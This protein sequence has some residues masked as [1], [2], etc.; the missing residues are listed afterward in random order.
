MAS[1]SSSYSLL[2][3]RLSGSASDLLNSSDS[4]STFPLPQ[5]S[6]KLGLNGEAY[7]EWDDD[8]IYP[9][10]DPLHEKVSSCKD[11]VSPTRRTPLS[12]TFEKVSVKKA[13]LFSAM[14]KSVKDFSTEQP[15]PTEQTDQPQKAE[16]AENTPKAN[17]ASAPDTV[18][19]PG[20]T[21]VAA[22]ERI[23]DAK[24]V[25]TPD[26]SSS[27][28]HRKSKPPTFQKR[29]MLPKPDAIP[30]PRSST[31]S[32]VPP[33]TPTPEVITID[34]DV[35]SEGPS[36]VHQSFSR[37]RPRSQPKPRPNIGRGTGFRSNKPLQRR[38]EVSDV[39]SARGTAKRFRAGPLLPKSPSVVSKQPT[40]MISVDSPSSLNESEKKSSKPTSF[41]N[42]QGQHITTVPLRSKPIVPS[43]VRRASSSMQRKTNSAVGKGRP[44]LINSSE[45]RI[46]GNQRREE[47]TR[48]S[49]TNN[50]EPPY[51][52]DSLL[53]STP[54]VAK[55]EQSPLS[56][57]NGPSKFSSDLDKISI[58][59]SAFSAPLGHVGNPPFNTGPPIAPDIPLFPPFPLPHSW[60]IPSPH[61]ANLNH[62]LGMPQG[63]HPNLAFPMPPNMHSFNAY[64]PFGNPPQDHLVGGNPMMAELPCPPH[65][66]AFPPPGISQQGLNPSPYVPVIAP[67]SGQVP[68][69]KRTFPYGPPRS[70]RNQANQVNISSSSRVSSDISQRRNNSMPTNHDEYKRLSDASLVDHYEQIARCAPKPAK[71]DSSNEQKIK[72]PTTEANDVSSARIEGNVSSEEKSPICNSD[73]SRK[74]SVAHR[75]PGDR[76]KNVSQTIRKIKRP[77]QSLPTDKAFTPT[78]GSS[79]SHEQGIPGPGQMDDPK[80]NISKLLE[81]A[82]EN[83]EL[84]DEDGDN[85]DYVS[86]I[87]ELAQKNSIVAALRWQFD[88]VSGTSKRWRCILT[89]KLLPYTKGDELLSRDAQSGVKKRA[90]HK[91]AKVFLEM[92]AEIRE[93]R[94]RESDKETEGVKD[95]EAKLDSGDGNQQSGAKSADCLEDSELGSNDEQ[96]LRQA[97][98]AL[99]SMWSQGYL[100]EKPEYT[101]DMEGEKWKAVVKVKVSGRD[102]ITV[103]CVAAQKK[104]ARQKV[105]L[106]ALQKLC[107][108]NVEGAEAFESLPDQ[109]CDIGSVSGNDSPQNVER[110]LLPKTDIESQARDA[111]ENLEDEVSWFVLPADYKILVATSENDCDEWFSN[112]VHENSHVGIYLDSFSARR[113]FEGEDNNASLNERASIK[114]PIICISTDKQGLVMQA[115]ARVDCGPNEYSDEIFWVPGA[116]ADVLECATVVKHGHSIMEGVVMLRDTFRVN[117]V[118]MD[119]VAVTSLAI[120]GVGNVQGEMFRTCLSELCNFWLRQTVPH[121]REE[122]WENIC[123][124]SQSTIPET[125]RQSVARGILAAFACHKL[126]DSWSNSASQKKFLLHGAAVEFSE[127]T[128][129]LMSRPHDLTA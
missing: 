85:T 44:R 98:T 74:I 70:Q 75:R 15:P 112:Y 17:S 121:F 32:L 127:L 124:H 9:G 57:A 101:M 88:D 119:D 49:N 67:K 56:M 10:F 53:T 114:W 42:A 45:S 90:K 8:N 35:S 126:P 68:V 117:C 6:P 43:L 52:S 25:D 41:Q 13:P 4:P 26:D 66:M 122:I 21:T 64:F 62:P 58:Q 7:G 23:G 59:K 79:A 39:T 89:G 40:P 97:Y 92:L 11:G 19:A 87:H 29:S 16:K 30:I 1:S 109:V 55:T 48:I 100:E 18:T 111:E 31:T 51:L 38:A 24:M 129:R 83:L 118:K 105:S 81:Q 28:A 128:S 5:T 110:P 104:L 37:L 69:A 72:A 108:M 107:K 93:Q 95:S 20:T 123:N 14:G 60:P 99:E 54:T 33:R 36:K 103:S 47:P 22:S 120:T 61:P 82:D 125:N 115:S 63:F 86:R 77:P 84:S 12:I 116:L 73:V 3:P 102:D 96:A 71:P 27:D 78:S 34:D 2:S 91:A 50:R 65:A 106:L 94:K 80:Q 76:V 113:S 46:T